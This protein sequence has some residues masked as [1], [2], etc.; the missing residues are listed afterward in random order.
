M[1]QLTRCEIHTFDCTYNGKSLHTRHTYHKT[2]VGPPSTGPLFKSYDAI[3][4]ELGHSSVDFLKIDIGGCCLPAAASW[5][6]PCHVKTLGG[7]HERVAGTPRGGKS[8]AWQMRLWA[9]GR[10][11]AARSQALTHTRRRLLARH[12]PAPYRGPRA[13][14]AGS[15][16]RQPR[17]AA[18]PDRH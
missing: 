17:A 14:R 9:W 1:L 7:A 4:K 16:A 5:G 11:A 12:T 13:K 2:C 10:Q 3:L 8:T 6:L 15:A 18:A